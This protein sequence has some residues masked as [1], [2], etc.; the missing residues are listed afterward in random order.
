M[1][2]SGDIVCLGN[3]FIGMQLDGFAFF[4]LAVH[5]EDKSIFGVEWSGVAIEVVTGGNGFAVDLPILFT[6]IERGV[7][8][9]I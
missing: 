8:C 7:D 4:G 9:S 1:V 3:D 6:S 2:Y 5:F